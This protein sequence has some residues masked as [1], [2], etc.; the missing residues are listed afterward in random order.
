MLLWIKPLWT[1]VYKYL[2]RSHFQ[3]FQGVYP[4]VKLLDQMATLF[5][6]FGGTSVLLH[7]GCALSHPI[8]YAQ[9]VCLSTSSPTHYFLGFS[10]HSFKWVQKGILWFVFKIFNWRIIALEYCA[11]FYH[12]STWISHRYTYVP[13][14]LNLLPTPHT[15]PPSLGCHRAPGWPHCVTQQLPISYLCYTG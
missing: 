6:V 9:G 14:L 1:Q 5:L 8:N 3:F 2:F 15:I 13:S 12:T 10:W 11:G 7:S 4:E